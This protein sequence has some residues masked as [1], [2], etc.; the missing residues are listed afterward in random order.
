[1]LLRTG[2][3]SAVQMNDDVTKLQESMNEMVTRAKLR[4]RRWKQVDECKHIRS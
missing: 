2:V 3:D 4:V 1:M